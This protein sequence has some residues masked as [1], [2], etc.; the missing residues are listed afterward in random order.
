MMQFDI[1]YGHQG[2]NP[3]GHNVV[4]LNVSINK[5]L[6]FISDVST[7]NKVG[8]AWMHYALRLESFTTYPM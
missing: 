2:Y 4:F 3:G 6:V 8:F 7:F 5:K 1:N